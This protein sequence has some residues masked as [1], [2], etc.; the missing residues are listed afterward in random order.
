MSHNQKPTLAQSFLW[1]DIPLCACWIL[2]E[3]IILIREKADPSFN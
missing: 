1:T 3:E 2:F